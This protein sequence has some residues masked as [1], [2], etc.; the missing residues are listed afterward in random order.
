MWGHWVFLQIWITSYSLQCA[1]WEWKVICVCMYHICCCGHALV[2]ASAFVCVLQSEYMMHKGKA[3]LNISQTAQWT[4]VDCWKKR[5]IM[6][7]KTDQL[8]VL[9]RNHHFNLP[10][11]LPLACKESSSHIFPL[12][13]CFISAPLCFLSSSSVFAHVTGSFFSR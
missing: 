8:P 11:D 7:R 12:P 3:A 4:D 2:H 1:K 9:R 5:Q 13:L 10:L 6:E